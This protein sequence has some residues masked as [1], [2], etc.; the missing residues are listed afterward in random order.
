MEGAGGANGKSQNKGV[1]M[2]IETQ[3]K[4]FM[5]KA[6]EEFKENIN[7]EMIIEKLDNDINLKISFDLALIDFFN[8][9][10]RQHLIEQL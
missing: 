3:L 1:I 7:D 4:F 6:W 8:R 5:Q 10:N 2:N 9:I